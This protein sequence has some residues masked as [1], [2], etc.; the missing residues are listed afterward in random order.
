[1]HLHVLLGELTRRLNTLGPDAPEV[2]QFLKEFAQDH[3]FQALARTA[4]ELKR[5][6]LVGR[7]ERLAALR[8]LYLTSRPRRCH[9]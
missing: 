9:V 8:E 5:Q 1:M 7:Q 2:E 6:V 3:E 4:R